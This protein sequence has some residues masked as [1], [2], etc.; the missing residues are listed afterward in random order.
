MVLSSVF[1]IA[2]LWIRYFVNKSFWFVVI[3]S[4][5]SSIGRGCSTH[6]PPKV[7]IKWFGPKNVPIVSSVMLIAA[8]FGYIIGYMF[9]ND[10][11]TTTGKI[12]AN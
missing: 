7:A 3:G 8:P 4:F 1:F 9:T 5:V 10:L 11:V 6:A 12:I 2:G